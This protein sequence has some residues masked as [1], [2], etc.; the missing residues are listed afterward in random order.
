LTPPPN[1]IPTDGYTINVFVDGVNLGHPTYNV[2]RSDIA[3]FFPGY[4]NSEG[5]HAYFD[6]DTTAYDNGVHNI[7]WTAEDSAGNS[8]GIGSRFF[9]IQNT[10]NLG[11][12][13]STSRYQQHVNGKE[14]FTFFQIAEIPVNALEP[15]KIKEN[16]REDSG[17]R[18]IEPDE[19]DAFNIKI[20]ELERIVIELSSESSVMGGY[21]I[22][23]NKLRALP[24]GS[25]LDAKKGIFY[26]QPGPA[27]I[28][29]YRFVFVEKIERM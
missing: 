2:Y 27:F 29:E 16:F 22:I 26:W 1:S 8:D 23:G 25:T 4:A 20:R 9:T 11:S 17:F 13:Q 10:G 19:E 3:A 12:R 14:L 6:F 15:I 5:A 18:F 7:Y 21:T 24:I 28:G